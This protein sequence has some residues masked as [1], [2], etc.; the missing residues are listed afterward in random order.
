MRDEV[1]FRLASESDIPWITSVVPRLHEFGPPRWRDTIVMERAQLGDV[2]RTI[3]EGPQR[4]L[5]L[6]AESEGMRHGFV[7]VKYLVDAMTDELTLHV[8]HVIVSHNWESRGVA[9]TLLS[10]AEDF[11]RQRGCRL[12]TLNVF[13][14]NT[15]ARALYERFGY[16]RESMRLVKPL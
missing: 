12:A 8:A 16:Q 1:T 5:V 10:A 4:G 6:I 11:G 2:S 13:L 7:H 15:R 14:D 3:A 9:R